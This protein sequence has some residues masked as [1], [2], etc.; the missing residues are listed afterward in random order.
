MPTLGQFTYNTVANLLEGG[1]VLDFNL[2]H[3]QSGA[4]LTVRIGALGDI[5]TFLPGFMFR[6]PENNALYLYPAFKEK[7]RRMNEQGHLEAL[8][9][10]GGNLSH[11]IFG[12]NNLDELIELLQTARVDEAERIKAF[13]LFSKQNIFSNQE[14]PTSIRLIADATGVPEARILAL[15]NQ[16]ELRPLELIGNQFLIA[17]SE[18]ID[19]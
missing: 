19:L 8:R 17:K 12:S 14:T 1:S 5:L 9:N 4:R 3:A 18:R 11:Y 7:L 6:T 15:A 10:A 2:R 16:R 13:M